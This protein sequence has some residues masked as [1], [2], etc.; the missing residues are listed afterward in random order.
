MPPI[1]ALIICIIFVLWLL[2]LDHKSSPDNSLALW[3]PTI[4]VLLIA[5]KPLGVWFFSGPRADGEMGSPLDRNFIITLIILGLIILLKRRFSFSKAVKDNY[6]LIFL[7]AFTLLSTLWSNIFFT[8]LARWI[9]EIL[10]ALIMSFVMLSE[11]NPREAMLSILRKTT[12]IHVPFS[13]L[14][15][16]YY[17]LL[18]V[19]YGRW[20]GD[21]MW[22]GVTTQKN[23]LGILCLIAVFFLSWSLIRRRRNHNIHTVRYQTIAEIFLLILSLLLLKGPSIL[24]MSATSATSLAAGLAAFIVLLRLS[25]SKI[26]PSANTLSV[27]TIAVIIIGTLSVFNEGQTV[28]FLTSS[29]GRDSTLTGRT[30][31]W[32]QYLPMAMQHPLLGHGFGGFWTKETIAYQGVNSVHNGYLEVILYLGFIGLIL[33][34]LFL[35]SSCQRAQQ[36]M[37]DDF[38]WVSLWLCFLFM[39]ILHNIGESSLDSFSRILTAILVFQYVASSSMIKDYKNLNTDHTIER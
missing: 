20:S 9:R 3:I 39:S 33:V 36:I 28:G 4:W 18:G 13:L 10:T 29:V 8:S 35:L 21:I 12:Y 32:R 14:L 38:Y 15:I 27:I 34:S 17:P 26:Y 6:L 7:A 11:N 1:L 31:I 16:K 30:D 25:K 22:I 19:Q 37:K 5:G 23:G 2:R 24:A